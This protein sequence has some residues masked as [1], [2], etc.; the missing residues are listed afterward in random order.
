MGKMKN[1]LMMVSPMS[2]ARARGIA[3]YAREHDW[4]L[5]IQ[6]RLGYHPLAW[7]GDGVIATL[8]SD[9][10]T[11]NMI[12]KLIKRGVPIVDMTFSR[13][14]VHVARVTSDHYGIGKLAAEHFAERNFRNVAWFSTGWGHVHELRYNGLCQDIHAQKWVLCDDVPK[15]RQHNW[16]AFSKWLARC[17]AASQKPV[18]VLTYDEADATRLLNI[19]QIENVA[20]PEEMAILSIGNDPL[21]CENQSVTLSSIDQNLELGGYEAAAMLDKIMNGESIPKDP[22]LVP[23]SGIVLRQS[24]DVVAVDDSLVRNAINCISRNIA[25]PIGASQIAAELCVSR[26]SLDKRFAAKLGRSIGEEICRQRIAAVKLRL[27]NT[28]MTI[29]KIAVETGFCTPSHLSNTF[30]AVLGMTPR[31][32]R[33]NGNK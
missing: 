33:L 29:A 5:M 26:N 4:R 3:R 24:T 20:V 22:V 28:D 15:A 18:G 16:S 6:D 25:R 30:H 12:R 8:R 14:E 7:R 1:V 31:Q 21:I 17:I 10:V 19:A 9:P 23:P 11:F 27:K 13:P 2:A 32:W